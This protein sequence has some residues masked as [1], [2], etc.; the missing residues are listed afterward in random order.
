MREKYFDVNVFKIIFSR[1]IEGNFG[2]FFGLNCNDL[3]F[4][5]LIMSEGKD[6]EEKGNYIC[7]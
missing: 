6:E 7:V 2:Y 5:I 4:F 1:F 3:N